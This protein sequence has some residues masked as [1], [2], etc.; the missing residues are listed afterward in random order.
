M[1]PLDAVARAV[2]KEFY[3]R[4]W[5]DTS[6]FRRNICFGIAKAAILALAECDW[7]LNHYWDDIL[8]SVRVDIED[9]AKAMLKALA[10]NNDEGK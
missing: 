5:D 10:E 1:T 7:P 2:C 8:A 6:E 3:Q 4:E 9:E